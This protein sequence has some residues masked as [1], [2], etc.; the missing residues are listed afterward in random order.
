[1]KNSE[2]FTPKDLAMDITLGWIHDAAT[3]KTRDVSS[4]SPTPGF[5]RE[6]YRQLSK[7][8]NR[9]LR[10]SGLDGLEIEVSDE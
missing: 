9:M 8:F 10:N 2:G 7:L 6:T 4:R 5:E 1:M 3:G